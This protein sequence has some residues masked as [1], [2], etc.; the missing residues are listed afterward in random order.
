MKKVL[1]RFAS[2]LFGK[3]KPVMAPKRYF[4]NPLLEADTS[5]LESLDIPANTLK[6]MIDD[7]EHKIKSKIKPEVANASDGV[8]LGTAGIA[9]MFYHLSRTPSLSSKHKEFM[10]E[11]LTYIAPALAVAE[12]SSSRK[13]DLPGFILGNSGVYAVA[14]TIFNAVADSV[15]SQKYREM[16]YEIAPI[17]KDTHFLRCGSDELFVGR[18]GKS[19]SRRKAHCPSVIFGW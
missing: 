18:A 15:Q 4:L 6:T 1:V 14:A 5:I 3:Q 7:I 16:F 12:R 9:Y 10:A 11:A 17:C 13:S 8:Y 2:S 19:A